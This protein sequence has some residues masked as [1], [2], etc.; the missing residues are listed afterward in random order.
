MSSVVALNQLSK[1]LELADAL[2]AGRD[3]MIDPQDLPG[4]TDVSSK[5]WTAF[6]MPFSARPSWPAAGPSGGMGISG[7][8]R[9]TWTL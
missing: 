1:Q 7:E 3:A 9:K 6:S 8:S 2:C 5:L 4:V